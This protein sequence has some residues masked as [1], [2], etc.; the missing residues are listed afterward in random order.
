MQATFPVH[1]HGCPMYVKQFRMWFSLRRREKES[2][3]KL[4]LYTTE[5]R[6]ERK[7]VTAQNMAETGGRRLLVPSLLKWNRPTC[8]RRKGPPRRVSLHFSSGKKWFGANWSRG[9]EMN[10]MNITV[11]FLCGGCPMNANEFNQP[12]NALTLLFDLIHA[13]ILV[14]WKLEQL[15]IFATCSVATLD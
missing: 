13:L 9:K 4:V 11:L 10:E 1:N 8:R 12:T 7:R 15:S 6:E 2:R 5:N 14:C 3:I